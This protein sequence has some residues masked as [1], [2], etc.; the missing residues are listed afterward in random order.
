MT[1][2]RN[3][4]VGGTRKDRIPLLLRKSA[5]G[6]AFA[7]VVLFAAG[8]C[9][10]HLP[11]PQ[12][13]APE[14]M[15]ER[16]AN[17]NG[18]QERARA[19]FRR[20]LGAK[21]LAERERCYLEALR[22]RPSYP[23]AHNN[24]GDVYEKQGRYEEALREYQIAVALVPKLA[25]FGIGDVS[26]TLGYYGTAIQA[27]QK[28]LAFEPEDEVSRRRLRISQALA[29][30]T[31][32]ALDSSDLTDQ[33]KAI[34]RQVAQAL[35]EPDVE[36]A[37][38][39]VQGHADSTGPA[40]YNSELSLARARRVRDFLVR[41]CGISPSRLVPRGYGEDRPLAS[42]ETKEGR[43]MNRR[44]GFEKVLNPT[45]GRPGIRRRR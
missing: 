3:A 36:H 1:R 13:E 21:G 43:A 28:G 18:A 8:G 19:S 10:H 40:R 23:E 41:E 17:A 30:T 14:G 35:E 45:S 31:G 2:V 39:E 27:Y 20:G 7:L 9:A 42:N 25:W 4:P 29:T 12:G 44:V 11:T 34:L 37:V 32:L 26:F 16:Q 15:G 22:E 24:L 5:V 38:F 33:T 6:L